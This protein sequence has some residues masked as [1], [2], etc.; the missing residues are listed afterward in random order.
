MIWLRASARGRA[1][2]LVGEAAL[3]ADREA[4][5]IG[6]GRLADAQ[7]ARL[8][9][10]TRGALEAF[11]AGVN[12]VLS[13]LRAGE[14]PLPLAL[15]GVEDAL[16][17]WTPADSLAVLKLEAWALGSSMQASLLL[18]DLIEALGGREAAAFFPA[19]PGRPR[20]PQSPEVAALAGTIAPAFVGGAPERFGS[21]AASL[22]RAVGLDARGAGSSA[23]VVAG[24][25]SA[26]GRPLVAGDSHAETTVPARF[27]EAHARGG[28][29]DV[30]GAMLPGAPV[31]FSGRNRHVAWASSFAPAVVTDLYVESLAADG[32]ARYHDA[33]GLQPLIERVETI[34][35]RGGP[36]VALRIRATRH[37]PLVNE[38][39]GGARPPLSIAWT[40]ALP[41]DGA[42]G[43]LRAAYAGNAGELRAALRGHGEPVLAFAYGDVQG[44][45][46]LQLA[47]TLPSRPLVTGFV[48]IPGRSD[49][50]DWSGVLPFELLPDTSL[51]GARTFAVASDGRFGAPSVS[52]DIEWLW[53]PGDTSARLESL[54]EASL[55]EAP[56]DVGRLAAL[57]RDVGSRRAL[58]IVASALALAGDPARLGTEGREVAAALA[59]WNGEVGAQ[60]VGAAL[61]QVFLQRV[62]QETLVAALGEPLARRYQQLPQTS[63]IA[64]VAGWLEAAAATPEGAASHAEPARR[65]LLSD[66]VRRSLRE[67]W[68]WLNVRVGPNREKWAWGHLHEIRFRGIGLFPAAAAD[69]TLGPFPYGG[70]ALTVAA[71]G[72][73]LLDPFA[74]RVAST[75]RFAIDAAQLDQA[76]TA[77]VPGQSEH[78]GSAHLSDAIP[79]WLAGRPRLLLTSRLLIEETKQTRLVLRP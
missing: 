69:P 38:L 63:P 37:G 34:A 73:D 52:D 20:P 70:D 22:R 39:V 11:S 15:R 53:L 14:D 36:S 2:E 78:P 5:T 51:E 47:G 17:R 46:G 10:P 56:L 16:E 23:L 31:V 58:S 26:S 35:V 3:P 68:L 40:G 43:L 32:S 62:V 8:D 28:A 30:A 25:A 55:R 74:V 75:H 24:R 48:P 65:A 7:L 21:D 49:D 6:I 45:A 42:T 79:D 41:G 72:F 77:L 76:I 19:P 27:Y 54:L 13:R 71:A 64:L 29:L 67:T 61:Y 18:A 50:Y 66:A 9:A 33:H 44:A 60:S 1:A 57:Q 59:R 12:V 4:R